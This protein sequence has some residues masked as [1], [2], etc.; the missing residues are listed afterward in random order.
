MAIGYDT[1]NFYPSQ[2]SHALLCLL[3]CSRSF[4][5]LFFTLCYIEG[6][7]TSAWRKEEQA[8]MCPGAGPSLV[9]PSKQK[10]V[11]EHFGQL[12][13]TVIFLLQRFS[14]QP[15]TTDLSFNIFKENETKIP[16]NQ[17]TT[18]QTA[19]FRQEIPLWDQDWRTSPSQPSGL[20]G[21][22]LHSHQLNIKGL[23][24]KF[25]DPLTKYITNNTK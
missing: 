1:V 21:W 22:E 9:H 25:P 3:C 13:W 5:R 7:L 11:A 6:H 14:E 17:T 23:E 15:Q 24:M 19:R 12:F 10:A 4:F 16:Q 8:S 18:T 20:F 2:S